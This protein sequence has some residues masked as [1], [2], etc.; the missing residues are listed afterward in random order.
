MAKDFKDLF[1]DLQAGRDVRHA[2]AELYRVVSAA[3]LEP[4]RGKLAG[5]ARSRLDAEDAL[6][7]AM[8]RALAN[9]GRVDCDT[10][11]QFLAWV[12][13]IA[14]NLIR[15]QAKR[16]SARAVP[17]TSGG[18]A[19]K[20]AGAGRRPESVLERREIIDHVLRRMGDREADVIR[21]R[22]LGG[23]SFAEIAAALDHT[24]KAVKGV[25]TRAWKR[26]RDLARKA[27]L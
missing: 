16:M 18:G 15:D 3:L 11:R 8:L 25:Y 24:Q 20:I 21:R 27:C 26:F 7:E 13:R 1:D 14:R 22:W 23:E 4:L 12:W 17:F 19:S 6:H 5:R 2:Q 10:E 9:V